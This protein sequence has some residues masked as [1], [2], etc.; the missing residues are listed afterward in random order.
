MLEKLLMAQKAI[1]KTEPDLM[2]INYQELVGIQVTWHRDGFFRYSVADIYNKVYGTDLRQYDFEP[3]ALMEKEILNE[4]C[5]SAKDVTAIQEL[6]EIQKSKYIMVNAW[7]LQNDIETH[8]EK[9][10]KKGDL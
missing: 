2:L 9:L 7:G 1:R 6:L 5:T 3:N 8:L 4:V 10:I